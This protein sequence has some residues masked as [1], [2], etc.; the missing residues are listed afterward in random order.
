MT[1]RPLVTDRLQLTGYRPGAI[2]R[3]TELHASYYHQQRGWGLAFEAEVATELSEFLQRFDAHRDGFWLASL[4]SEIVG[5]IAISGQQAAAREA[6]LRWFIVSPNCRG[7]GL[8]RLLMQTAI[9][10][11][12]R[13]E[14]DRVYLW[15]TTGL[16]AAH[17]LYRQ[18]GFVLVEEFVDD[19]WGRQVVH[20]RH[21]LTL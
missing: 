5:S 20:Q 8:G 13:A 17:H 15:T 18:F 4:D 3:I 14:F 10:F 11:C 7:Y 19:H 16:D 12:H 6:R 21:L 1:D 9:A 2:G